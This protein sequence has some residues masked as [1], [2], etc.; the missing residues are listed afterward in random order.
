MPELHSGPSCQPGSGKSTSKHLSMI[1]MILI[2]FAYADLNYQ[3]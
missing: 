3:V 2:E 1:N